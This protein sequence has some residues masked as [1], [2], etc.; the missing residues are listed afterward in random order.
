MTTPGQLTDNS[1]ALAA[2]GRTWE[3]FWFT[4]A[5][6][7]PL[8]VVRMAAGILGLLA[9]ATYTQDLITWFGSDGLLPVE[10]VVAWRAPAAVSLFDVCGT[11][12]A[13]WSAFIG[14]MVLFGL[15]A[16]GLLTPVVSVLAALGWVSLLHRGPMLAGPADDC[17]AILLWCV[18]LGAAGEHFSVDAW[19]HRRLGWAGGRPRVR[20]RL[21]F[22]L[23]QIHAAVIA[24]AA[25]LAQLKGDIWWNGTAMWWLTTRESG[26]LLN[27]VKPL[28]GSEYLCNALTLG[29]V[30]WEMLFAVGLWFVSAQR[31]VA[32][33][34]L[35][36][37][38]LVGLLVAEPLWG[39]VMATLTLPLTGLIRRP[40][41][42]PA[43]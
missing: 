12:V 33:C 1:T 15:L 24:V 31:L 5:D 36:A 2:I 37:W 41:L 16:I 22:G 25:V 7:R 3:A 38:P 34:A 8:A 9:G 19:L 17:L 40:D 20:T 10:T 29:I 4:P 13:V 6:S 35:I 23:L 21:A 27:L 14:L 11:T 43:D 28:L 18:A 30:G 26:R 39:I 32:R 42:R